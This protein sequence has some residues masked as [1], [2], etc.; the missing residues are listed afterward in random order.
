VEVFAKKILIVDHQVNIRKLLAT[1]LN[2]LGYKIIL[3]S[4][5]KDALIEFITES[6]DLVIIDIML[7]KLDGYSVCRKIRENSPIPIIILTAINSFSDRIIGLELGAD[8]YLVKPFLPKE[9]EARVKSLLRRNNLQTPK[10]QKQNH[11]NLQIGNLFIDMSKR[12]ISKNNSSVSL[13]KIEYSLLELFL[14]NAG[15]ELSRTFILDNVWG[16]TPERQIDTRIVDVH[17]SRLRFKIEEDANNPYLIL[18]VRGIG[19]K[20][21]KYY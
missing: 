14:E 6:P 19:Y 16:F 21:Q 15:T 9:L 7:P 17:I 4:N 2:L 11:K 10:L 18:T 20:F 12:V 1:R 3:A 13:T 5:G 8:D